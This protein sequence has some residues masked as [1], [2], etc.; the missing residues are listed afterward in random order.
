VKN[1]ESFKNGISKT[2]AILFKEIVF[3]SKL[4]ASIEPFLEPFASKPFLTLA[5]VFLLSLAL[6]ETP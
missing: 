2:K 3:S 4:A 6:E 5:F 1:W